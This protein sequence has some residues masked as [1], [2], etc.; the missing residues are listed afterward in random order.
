MIE[1]TGERFVPTE[2]GVIRQE[3]LHRYAWCQRLAAGKDVLDIA[4]GE[5]YGS[6]M[7]AEGARSVVGVDISYEAAAH[8]ASKYKGV[9]N[10]RYVQG[11][12]AAIPLADDSVDIVVSFETIEHLLEQEEM[13]AEIRRVLR[14][15][16]IM[17]MSSP[18]KEIYS[19][20]AGYHND[21][22]VKELYLD[23]FSELVSRYFPA[24]RMSSHRMAVCST[25]TPCELDPS[26][27]SYQ[28]LT[29]TGSKV[30]GRVADI[31]D[32][33]YFVVVAAADEALL[34]F[35][36][37]SMLYAESED[38]FAHHR[39]VAKWAQAQ[40]AEIGSLR[41]HV[42][43][44]QTEVVRLHE[45]VGSERG[46][47]AAL[48]NALAQVRDDYAVL[49]GAGALKDEEIKLMR[50]RLEAAEQKESFSAAL[51]ETS[52]VELASLQD[53]LREALAEKHAAAE[54][55]ATFEARIEAAEA[56]EDT[57]KRSL[58]DKQAELAALELRLNAELVLQ[59][60][61][62]QAEI[63]ALEDRRRVELAELDAQMQKE[64]VK[65]MDRSK[66]EL[67]ELGAQ[68]QMELVKLMDRS[69]VELAELGAQ[70]QM[71]LVKL[72]GRHKVE[73]AE[74]EAQKQMELV[75]L[76]DRR[77]IELA[78][79]EAQKHMELAT[80]GNRHKVDL[81]ELDRLK[82][83]E[84]GA[85]DA[86]LRG[87][88]IAAE[89]RLQ[90]EKKTFDE[91]LQA[92]LVDGRNAK[93]QFALFEERARISLEQE[94]GLK[95]AIDALNADLT[96]ERDNARVLAT[97]MT[98]L[99]EV[100]RKMQEEQALIAGLTD[101]GRAELQEHQKE[102][103]RLRDKAGAVVPHTQPDEDAANRHDV[104][105]LLHHYRAE[106]ESLQGLSN[107][108]LQ[109]R[110][111]RIT[112]P[113][114]LLG[115]V[116]RGEWGNVLHSVR[117]SGVAQHP[118]AK[119]F[120]PMAKRVL[121]RRQEGRVEPQEGLA[122]EEVQENPDETLRQVRFPVEDAPVVTI[123]IPTY[124]NYEQSLACVASI[125]RIGADVTFE[126][127]VLE[128]ASG[129]SNIGKLESIPGLR[130]HRNSINLGFLRS[131]NQALT[132]AKGQFICLLNN[133]TE[134]TR[135]WLD[136][137]VRVFSLRPDAGLVGS[138]LI[139]P[140]GRL[141]EAG[142]IVWADGS[143]WNFGRLDDPSKPA[144][145]Y[146]KEADYVS[147][148]SI[149]M[150]ADVFREMGGFDDHYAPA[151]YED[152]DM[153]FRVRER[154]M[155]VYLQPASVVVHYEGVSSGTDESSGV[156]A[157][158]AV[159]R[160]KF[161]AR[162]GDTLRATQFDNGDKVFMARDRSR[163]RRRVLVVDHYVPQPDRDAGSRA[164]WQV[165]EMLVRQGFQ[166]TF[167]PANA[168]HDLVYTPPLQELGVEVL[169]GSE[170]VGRFDS[171]MA[172][173]GAN[174][175]TVVLN[176]PHISVDL[177]SSVRNHSKA[178]LVYYGH[179]IH[180]LRMQQQLL[181]QPDRELELETRRFR[182]FEH[183]LW[184]QSD[185]VLY[186]STDETTHVQTWLKSN[187][188]DSRTCA[189]TIPLY[190][191]DRIPDEGVPPA[192]ARNDI[193]FVAG[194]AHAP[195]VDAATWF[196]Q[197][198][199]PLVKQQIPSVKVTLVG[200]NPRPEVLAMASSDVTVTGYVSDETLAGYYRRSRVSVAPLRFGG[201]VKGK[202]LESLRYGVP[203][204]TTSIGMQGLGDAAKF[205]QAAD[206]PEALAAHIVKL[207]QDDTHWQAVSLAE[208][209]FIDRC[210]SRDALWNV[211]GAAIGER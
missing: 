174:L 112:R 72:E 38:L 144:Y 165:L 205:M 78:E 180:H 32:A 186:P 36:P 90:S 114:R 151:Y 15:D 156:K 85:L 140:D 152:T 52:A 1:F 111:W 188:P 119:P 40:D 28:A 173:H 185:V 201:G 161:L 195:N 33:V 198:I 42:R 34:P 160:V 108:L 209:E 207:L 126:V 159:N 121:L 158:Q 137:L 80:L 131:C 109:S 4:S 167:W 136:A 129:D 13:M 69:K 203:C 104:A 26:Q 120:V 44:E 55:M 22:H 146:L 74:L 102:I 7:L 92:A 115:R 51:M 62:K 91:Q 16:G 45:V 29:D 200:S 8:A 56:R 43:R 67:A 3:H 142:G 17:V 10:L 54:R 132:L 30:E 93:E 19:D 89:E 84:L 187:A 18:N 27:N 83:V 128:D 97:A 61:R 73:L 6:A 65:L 41:E 134:V 20:Q 113:L 206:E 210:Y 164:T 141:Q 31:T 168:F 192:A 178:T 88:L 118:L 21:F 181:L 135:G 133:D 193:L 117:A 105:L 49:F 148:A 107:R 110:S 175:D 143:A 100:R 101:A 123:V 127:L 163:H 170:Y 58:E 82:K 14:P 96:R 202:V 149:M 98:E 94:Q 66:G 147:G 177:V 157:W 182:V 11:S 162:W 87:E 37:A 184:E 179:D 172:E 139:Y 211:L 75:M 106:L 166:V 150:R 79:L 24:S 138:K 46:G 68:K 197:E 154:G 191:Y 155:K 103:E 50:G 204:V 153:A 125:A 5:G 47:V 12:A 76:E 169:Y 189:Q 208:R 116:W 183:A 86:L 35:L 190:A 176:R 199:L 124:G 196:V 2:Q 57:L 95:L 23:E 171:W 39:E 60:E 194:F 63:A 145:N 130:Y 71:E 77:K 25:I 9:D 64:L 70:K 99:W 59:G 53:L 81:A 122:F 48:Q